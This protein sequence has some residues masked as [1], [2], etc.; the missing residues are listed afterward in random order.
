MSQKIFKA[1]AILAAAM[2]FTLAASA[3]QPEEV[4]IRT[5]KVDGKLIGVTPD[6]RVVGIVCGYF[7]ADLVFP[8]KNGEINTKSY[9][10]TGRL[11]APNTAPYKRLSGEAFKKICSGE[12]AEFTIDIAGREIELIGQ[13]RS[14]TAEGFDSVRKNY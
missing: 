11:I 4:F 7:S 5:F 13:P 3:Q 2:A 8:A 12:P 14:Y 6:S 9:N 10:A 1:C